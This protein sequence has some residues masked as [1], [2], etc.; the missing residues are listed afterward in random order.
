M[1]WKNLTNFSN[2]MQIKVVWR[3]LGVMPMSIPRAHFTDR[4]VGNN[5]YFSNIREA[6][7]WLA[8]FDLSD[9]VSIDNYMAETRSA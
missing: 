4:F 6:R 5:G 2:G 9:Q 1:V 8:G 3:M 7:E